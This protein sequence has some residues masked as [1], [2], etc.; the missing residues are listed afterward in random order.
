MTG[1]SCLNNAY[2]ARYFGIRCLDFYFDVI[3]FH[4]ECCGLS[5]GTRCSVNLSHTTWVQRSGPQSAVDSIVC[6]AVAAVAL[7]S[8]AIECFGGRFI[9]MPSELAGCPL[10]HLLTR[11]RPNI[12]W[13]WTPQTAL[14]LRMAPPVSFSWSRYPYTRVSSSIRFELPF[15]GLTHILN[16]APNIKLL[17]IS[18][19]A[20]DILTRNQ[21][22]YHDI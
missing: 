19:N 7:A 9:N 3:I 20:A 1:S 16:L 17:L 15:E 21:P 11:V 8:R 6:N 10:E 22:S 2:V 12:V 4:P 13:L 18:P 14:S 5:F